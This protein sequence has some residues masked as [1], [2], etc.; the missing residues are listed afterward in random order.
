MK[1]NV[2]IHCTADLN[3][4]SGNVSQSEISNLQQIAR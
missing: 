3:K 4:L 1:T 2:A